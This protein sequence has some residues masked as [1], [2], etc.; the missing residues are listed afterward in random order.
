M[1]W[2]EGLNVLE[3]IDLLI[4]KNFLANLD[5]YAICCINYLLIMLRSVSVLL[6]H[7]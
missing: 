1:Y 7:I 6:L 2:I 4:K 5:F 3:L